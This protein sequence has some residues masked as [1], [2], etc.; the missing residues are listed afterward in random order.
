VNKDTGDAEFRPHTL[1]VILLAAIPGV[2]QPATRPCQGHNDRI[3]ST[4]DSKHALPFTSKPS[5]TEL[6]QELVQSESGQSSEYEHQTSICSITAEPSDT[7]SDGQ[8]CISV[9]A[10]YRRPRRLGF[11]RVDDAHEEV[12]ERSRKYHETDEMYFD[13]RL[14][15]MA[16]YG[17]FSDL[18]PLFGNWNRGPGVENSLET[19]SIITTQKNFRQPV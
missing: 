13:R 14:R 19:G 17:T 12:L 18:A 5:H 16:R 4:R 15:N 9:G 3:S 8:L 2:V 10:C 6:G 7:D 11:D 1:F